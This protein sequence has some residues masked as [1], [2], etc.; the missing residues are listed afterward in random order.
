MDNP[1]AI[2]QLQS[3]I[4]QKQNEIDALNAALTVLQSG[5]QADQEANQ[6]AIATAV[7]AAQTA[8]KIADAALITR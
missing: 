4:G 5:Y 8:Q 7:T 1:T 3:L 2:T 6:T